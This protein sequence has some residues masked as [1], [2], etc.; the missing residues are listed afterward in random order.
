MSYPVTTDH[1][2]NNRIPQNHRSTKSSLQTG[3]H[4]DNQSL[5]MHTSQ[6]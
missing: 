1:Y 4:T 2:T 3:N 6:S 5:E